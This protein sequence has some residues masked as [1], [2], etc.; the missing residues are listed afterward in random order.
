MAPLSSVLMA[1]ALMAGQSLAAYTLKQNYE[2]DTFLDGFEF[3]VVCRL[4]AY[5]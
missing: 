1:T 4:E 3:R 2:G 5:Q